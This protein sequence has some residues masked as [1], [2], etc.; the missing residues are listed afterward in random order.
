MRA[1]PL[2]ALVMHIDA[3]WM[4][5]HSF[6]CWQSRAPTACCGHIPRQS[7]VQQNHDRR[8]ARAGD[9]S[10]PTHISRQ[11][12]NSAKHENAQQCRPGIYQVSACHG[13]MRLRDDAE[14][15]RRGW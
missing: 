15:L 4:P 10:G 13:R 6:D 12:G 1:Y 11:L 9:L 7:L 8:G 3:C 2:A 14:P 5:S